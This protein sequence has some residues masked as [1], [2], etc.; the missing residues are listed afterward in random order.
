MSLTASEQ[1][2]LYFYEW[3][4]RNRGYYHFDT[5]IDIEPPYLPFQHRTYTNPVIDDGRIP[6]LFTSIRKLIIPQ[7]KEEKQENENLSIDPSFLKFDEQPTLVGFSISFPQGQEILPLRNIELL[8]MLSFTTHLVSFELVGIEDTITLQIVCSNLDSNRVRS[9]LKA[10]FPAIIIRNCD[11]KDFG[12]NLN[13]DIAIADFGVHDE[14]M[15]SIHTSESFS[16]DPLTSIIATLDSLEQG[17]IAVF[18]ILFKGITSPL[19]KDI[20]NAVSDGDG[21]SFFSDAPEMPKCADDKISA[22]LFSVVMRIGTQGVNDNRS[23][24]LATELARSITS[25]SHS[26]Y[27]KLIP[28][29][30]EGYAYDFHEYNLRNRLSN[31]LGF[32]LNS[33]EL[34]TFVHYPNKT[35][36][37]NKL[38]L[39]NEKTKRQSNASLSGIYIGTNIHLEQEFPVYL[40]TESRLSHTHIIGAT[41]VGKSTLIAN[42]MLA[43]IEQNRG[44]AIFDPHGDICDDILKRI[45]E[46]RKD[47][48]IIIDPSDSEHPIGF[49]LLEAHTEPEKIVLSS[50]LVSAFKRHATAWGDNMTAVLQNAVNTILE[51]IRGGTIIELKRFLIEES[52]RNEYLTSVDDP[53]LH[54]YWQNEYP[55]VRKGIAPLLTRIDTFLRPKLVRYMLAQKQGVDISQCLAENKIV[56][57]KLSQGLIGEHNSY[58]LGSL[59]LAKFNQAALSRQGQSK[60]ERTPYMLYLDEFQN[61]I[62]PS[63]EKILS[64]TRKYGL[65]L[66]IAHQELGQIQDLSLLNSVISNPK[67]RICFRLGDSDAKRLESGFSYF[68]QTDLQS[69]ERGEVIMRIGSSSNDFNLLTNPL[70][71]INTDYSQT[72]IASV[73]KQ[74]GT[75]K[76]QVKDLL[77]SM[78]PSLKTPSFKKKTQIKEKSIISNETVKEVPELKPK[79]LPSTIPDDVKNKLIKEENESLEI[80]SHTYL[81]SM[82]KKLG[83]DRNYIATTEYPT[84]DG[85][86]IDIVL[87]KDGLKIGFEISETN[88]PSY[89]VKNIKKCLKA[90]CI[91]VVM[92]S[93]NKKQLDAI[94]KLTFQEL[95]TKDK[96]LVQFIQPD[97]IPKILDSFAF[98]P[99]KQ[100]EMVKG[101]RIVTEFENEESSQIKNIKSRLNKL[102][103]RKK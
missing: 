57:L 73:R 53:S 91:P 4:Y 27:N 67:I 64:G 12:F 44:C 98:Q 54:Y 3:E 87:E 8:N 13:Q 62:T 79:S 47:D 11:I 86:R 74:Y 15:R 19:A 42:M 102:F 65:G 90:G 49:N 96:A 58:L 2:T 66:T 59:F 5:P 40:D 70:R 80:R 75:P 14:F 95:S 23:H 76:E 6:G 63:I 61:F 29:S 89:E 60:D 84:K 18:Q 101:F 45:P 17:D 31:R 81:Q 10:Y 37:S 56:L 100:E 9:H 24:Y 34:N 52:F 26:G 99:Q 36:V 85:G 92:V 71:E 46:H 55:M 51:S 30:N 38:G 20:T 48:V 35:V 7:Q 28:L 32:I 97:E 50:D 25:I 33:K 78:L 72:I 94:E 82:I 43:D 41:G 39:G 68:E 88:K 83:Q 16:I 21:G 77:F 103:K 93:K 22:P 1:A 69:L